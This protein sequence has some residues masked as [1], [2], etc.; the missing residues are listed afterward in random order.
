M[1]KLTTFHSSANKIKIKKLRGK[2]TS[3]IIMTC[4]LVCV[5][6]LDINSAVCR[7]TTKSKFGKPFVVLWNSPTEGCHVN[8]RVNIELEKYGILTNSN[9]TWNGEVITVFYNG[10]LGLYPYYRN[11]N[12]SSKVN[13]GLPQVSDLVKPAASH[14]RRNFDD[15]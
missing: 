13:D 10:Q 8:F 15:K 3:L 14:H 1:L 7:C 2:Q 5:Q 9:Q 4:F 12:K 11:D 6:T